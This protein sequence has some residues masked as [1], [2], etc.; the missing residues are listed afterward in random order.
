M[1]D[2]TY[3]WFIVAIKNACNCKSNVIKNNFWTTYKKINQAKKINIIYF[4]TH[5]MH[6][7]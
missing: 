5:A 2:N 3:Y 4:E 7:N 6:Q 1:C